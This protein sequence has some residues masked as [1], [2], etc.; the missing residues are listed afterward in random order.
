MNNFEYYSPT[1]II[2]GKDTHKQV[3]ELV[4]Q[5][6]GTGK[7]LF[8]FGGSSIKASGLYGQVQDALR[9]SGVDF[10]ELGGVQPNPRLKL[11]RE[12]VRLCKENDIRLIL[13]VGGGSV[14][15]SAKAA[16][17]GA[18][19]DGDVWDFYKRAAVPTG[20]LPV[21]TILTIPAAGSE[22][23]DG[24]VITNEETKDKLS[25]DADIL[26]PVFSILNPALCYTLPEY[27]IACGASD[28][29]AHMM[30]R[31]FTNTKAV[32]YSDRAIEAGMRCL[33]NVAPRVYAAETPDYDDWCNFVWT[34]TMAHSNIIGVDRTQD[35]ASHNIEHE[36]SALYDIAH[37]AGLSIVFP[38]WIRH[39]YKDNPSRFVQ[40]AVRVFDVDLAYEDA[41]A[42]VAEAVCRLE[43]FYKTL[44]M[45]IRLSD[46]NI[47]GENLARMAQKA[48]RYGATGN[49]KKLGE[50][51]VLA[52]L[53]LAL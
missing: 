49:L 32:D 11:V 46:A 33:L 7:V 34:G 13:A 53:K 50:Q 39:V 6:A 23:S 9:G 48:V 21:A 45:P 40:W 51:D 12:A 36:I 31:Y 3:G 25:C 52:I 47:D 16:A 43:R 19:Y 42:I 4:K 8:H 15:D 26:R 5:Y 10:L 22:S 18:L 37:G 24:S 17:L 14:I 30:E 2:F 38:A 20:A 1:R 29:L 41:D 28:I 35:W 27:Q 44:D